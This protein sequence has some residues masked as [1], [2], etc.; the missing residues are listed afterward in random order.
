MWIFIFNEPCFVT[1]QSSSPKPISLAPDI[2]LLVVKFILANPSFCCLLPTSIL[3]LD[4]RCFFTQGAP[5]KPWPELC[6]LC[7]GIVSARSKCLMSSFSIWLTAV[8]TDLLVLQQQSMFVVSP[9]FMESSTLPT[10]KLKIYYNY[11]K[12]LN[13]E[14]KPLEKN[15]EFH[16]KHVENVSSN[17]SL[18]SIPSDSSEVLINIDSHYVPQYNTTQHYF[19]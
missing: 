6:F 15:N 11:I 4:L 13:E 9:L 3:A 14:K 18:R 2:C 1:F 12:V 16:V 8:W 17:I 7:V 10:R 19:M 5:F